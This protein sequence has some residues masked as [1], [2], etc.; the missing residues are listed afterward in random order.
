MLALFVSGCEKSRVGNFGFPAGQLQHVVRYDEILWEP[1]A[2][3][4]PPGCE[5]VV[6][7]GNPQAADFFAV[8]FRVT[9]EFFMP[10]HTHPKDERVT[11]MSGQ[12]SVAFGA[13][14]SRVDAR[15]FGPGDYYINARDTIHSVW[16]DE[17]TELQISGI[18]PW[19]VDFIE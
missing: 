10:P 5:G 8:R 12:V 17:L 7:E 18:G 2:P 9:D 6:L 3:S 19:A 15:Q 11:V 1:C 14:A 13:N 4:L 16:A